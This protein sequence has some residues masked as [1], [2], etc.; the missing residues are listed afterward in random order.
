[1]FKEKAE[2]RKLRS[3]VLVFLGMMM[4][5]NGCVNSSEKKTEGTPI[6]PTPTQNVFAKGAD[7]SWLPEME[8]S[9]FKFYNSKGTE[10]DCLQILKD[11]GMDTIR[12]RTWVNPSND[13]LNGHCSS[14]E[15]VAMAVRCKKLGYRIMID[16]HYSDTWCDPGKQVKPA[17][18]L[19]HTFDELQNDVYTY[20]FQVMTDLKTAGI[21]PEWVQVGNEINPGMM[22]PDGSSDNMPNLSKLINKGYE[23]VKA[24]S[25]TS[26]VIIH[27]AN[28]ANN[29]LYRWFFDGLSLNLTKY[30]VI[31]LSYYP[32]WDG[33]NYKDNIEALASNMNDMVSRYNK[34][35][36][37]VEVGGLDTNVSDTYD[38]LS[39]VIAK[40]KAIPNGKGLGVLYWEPQGAHSWS[41]YSLSCWSADGK[42]TQALEAFLK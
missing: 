26:K 25:P 42:P 22:L 6:V 28:G 20:T 14:A 31:G 8:K 39:A 2:K 21:T 34:E 38:M 15:T 5:V 4:F 37:V 35:V 3:G 10:Q 33:V 16:F 41:G 19:N 13:K 24:V 27:L 40:V 12:L 29:G 11:N 7:V 32:H 1:M 23:A 36:M 30:D 9:G 18:W 17:A